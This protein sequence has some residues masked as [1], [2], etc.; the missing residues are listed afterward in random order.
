MG[1]RDLP[2]STDDRA[3]GP[4]NLACD[5]PDGLGFDPEALRAKYARERQRRLRSDGIAQY[6]ETTGAFAQF[7]QDPW[8]DAGFSREPIDDEVDVAVIGAGFVDWL[9]GAR[10]RELGVRSVRL[11]DKAADVGGT[12]CWNRYPGIA[13][14][15]ESYVYMPLLEELDYVPTDEASAEA[16]AAWADVVRQRSTLIMERRKACTPGYTTRKA[17]LTTSCGRA[18][19]SSA[20]RRNTPTSC[21]AGGPWGRRRA[22]TRT[23]RLTPQ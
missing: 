21:S 19:S 12:W 4:G 13:C 1:G 10:L 18:A 6:V 17:A 11:I 3:D 20:P 16:E 14:D 8:A 5:E 9:T 15:V 7:A 2:P 23:A 22:K